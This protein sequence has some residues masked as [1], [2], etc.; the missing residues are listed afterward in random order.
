MNPG[1]TTMPV[2][3]IVRAAWAGRHRRV[4]D[5]QAP[6]DACHGPGSGRRTAAIDQ[7]SAGDQQVDLRRVDHPL[8]LHAWSSTMFPSGSVT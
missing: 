1:A 3:S 5:V 2:A 4:A 8:P 6:L 7:R